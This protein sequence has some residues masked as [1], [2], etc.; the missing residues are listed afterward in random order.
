MTQRL[1]IDAFTL[2]SETAEAALGIKNVP[3]FF[4]ATAHQRIGGLQAAVRYFAENAS[5][6][7]IIVEDD[8]DAAA[9]NQRLEALSDVVEPGRKLIVIGA[10]NDITFYRR[11]ISM[12]VAEYLLSPCGINDLIGAIER[13]THDPHAIS[14]GKTFTFVGA[15]GGTG[16]STVAHNVAWNLAGQMEMRVILL[17]LDL[18]FGTAALAFNEEPRQPLIDALVDPERLDPI[19]L[20]RFMVAHDENL[21]ILSTSGPTRNSVT[22]SNMAIEKLI[23]LAR[24]MADIVVIDL[25]HQW[26]PW[27]EELLIPSDETVVTA[28]LDLANLRDARHLL[29]WLRAKRGEG[30][31]PR[32]V[33]NKADMARRSRLTIK[34]ALNALSTKPLIQV[35]FDPVTFVE[36]VND[37]KMIAEKNKKHK[38]AIAFQQL[39]V[40]LS[41]RPQ[42]SRNLLKLT[43]WRSRQG[44]RAARA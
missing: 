41:G 3:A 9:L 33:I 43:P 28:A 21:Q 34:D 23:D 27:T 38:A 40:A 20:Q 29:D 31:D 7:V 44:A 24:Q 32:L 13:V 25:P 22:I 36:A 26:H 35:P 8:G 2:T 5:P 14:K 1:T 10:V 15:R 42:P 39:A 37:G 16:S 19:L 11:L 17:D 4:R 12:G 18:N 30:R 6:Q